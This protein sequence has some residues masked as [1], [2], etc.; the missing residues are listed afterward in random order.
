LFHSTKNVY[1]VLNSV[2]SYISGLCTA[3]VEQQELHEDNSFAL[4]SDILQC[5]QRFVYGE[6]M[7]I[8]A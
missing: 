5:T 2:L 6:T 7:E 1:H 3:A 8:T 4:T